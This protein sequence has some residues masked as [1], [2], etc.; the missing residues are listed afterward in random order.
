MDQRLNIRAKTI[1]LLEKNIGNHTSL[2][3]HELGSV[4]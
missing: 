3:D 4:S 1:K 2:H